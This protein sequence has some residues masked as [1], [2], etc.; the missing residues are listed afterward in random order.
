MPYISRKSRR[1][2]LV[3]FAAV[4]VGLSLNWQ[5][6]SH[7]STCAYGAILTV[8]ALT[9]KRRILQTS[10]RRNLLLGAFLLVLLFFLRICRWEL[11]DFFPRIGR[12]LW[13]AYYIPFTV[14]P[15]CS[16][17]AALCVGREEADRPLRYAKWLWAVC[18]LLIAVALTNDFHGLMFRFTEVGDFSDYGAAYYVIVAWGGLLTLAAFVALM[19]RCQLSRSRRFWFV[20]VLA[21]AL[22]SALLLWYYAAG[23]APMM[24]GRK[25]FN[26]QEAYAVL[27]VLFWEACIQIGLIPSNTDYGELFR[28]SHLNAALLD[29]DGKAVLCA[30][31]YA[32]QNDSVDDIRRRYAITGGEIVWTEDISAVNRLGEDIADATK[33]IEQ[34]NDLIKEENLVI[35]EKAQLDE[36]NRLYDKIAAKVR[37]QLRQIGAALSDPPD[38]DEAFCERLMTAAILGAYVKRRANLE[39]LGDK[40]KNLSSEQLLYAIRESFEYLALAG[41]DCEAWQN[42]V[43]DVPSAFL[44]AAYDLFEAALEA[45]LPNLGAYYV[46]ME[47]KDGFSVTLALSN[48]DIPLDTAAWQEMLAVTGGTLT[49]RQEDDTTRIIVSV[50]EGAAL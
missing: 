50:G 48:G 3:F 46:T 16:L 39:L 32:E 9:V 47:A 29:K 4:L 18:F 12:L 11:A 14:T 17:C 42:G 27:F 13:Y 41:T 1:H 15:L 31:D 40:E 26:L 43:T 30:A 22:G 37:P 28:L 34:E 20:P 44:I 6:V 49:A 45:A 8:W 10:I 35:A 5:P 19:R 21:A 23:G 2:I 24:G 7:F 38:E 33:T 36:Q 25:L